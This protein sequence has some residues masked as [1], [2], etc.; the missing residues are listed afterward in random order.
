MTRSTGPV[1]VSHVRLRVYPGG[2]GMLNPGG[3][4]YLGGGRIG[5]GFEVAFER[6]GPG[7]VA[8]RYDGF[9]CP[10]HYAFTMTFRVRGRTVTV[11]DA[12]SKGCIISAALAHD[13]A[14]TTFRVLPLPDSQPETPPALS[15]SG[16]PIG[17]LEG[18]N[19]QTGH[20]RLFLKILV[21]ADGS[22][23]FSP[24]GVAFDVTFRPDGPSQVAIVYDNPV[25]A[26]PQVVTLSFAVRDRTVTIG[27]VDTP[28]NGML[29]KASARLIAGSTLRIL[30]APPTGLC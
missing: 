11:L 14:G 28:G 1:E 20:M 8:V 5:G 12:Q 19:D 16:L 29:S 24:Y 3:T 22:G 27:K 10:S 2:S 6:L 30:P 26:D 18:P 17:L 15:P 23:Q 7:R 21:R 25:L 4:A 9:A 13:L